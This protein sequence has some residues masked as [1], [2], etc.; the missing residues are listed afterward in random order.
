MNKIQQ[1]L[2]EVGGMQ[3]SDIADWKESAG[4]NLSLHFTML[5]YDMIQPRDRDRIKKI[6]LGCRCPVPDDTQL[7]DCGFLEKYPNGSGN[8]VPESVYQTLKPWAE[9]GLDVYTC[10]CR[11]P[12][13][14]DPLI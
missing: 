6:I 9:L 14:P 3:D 5:V 1:W 8:Y 11:K 12:K 13:S 2:R 10:N 7:F 4:D